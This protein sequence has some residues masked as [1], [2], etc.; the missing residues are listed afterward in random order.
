MARTKETARKK[1]GKTPR[2]KL[3][4]KAPHKTLSSE[5]ARKNAAKAAGAQKNLGNL[6]TGGLKRPMRYHQ[7][8]VALHQIHRYQ[9]TME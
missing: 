6:R 9:K 8:M 1:T 4:P 7:G 5:Q 2:H 3:I